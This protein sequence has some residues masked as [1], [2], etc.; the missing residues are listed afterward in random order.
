MEGVPKFSYMGNRAEVSAGFKGGNF[1]EKPAPLPAI[2]IE[3]CPP[4]VYEKFEA[5]PI[6]T[7]NPTDP[8]IYR[9]AS[10]AM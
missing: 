1:F 5:Q 6:P 4:E 9:K 10:S 8:W 2:R 7:G 3:H